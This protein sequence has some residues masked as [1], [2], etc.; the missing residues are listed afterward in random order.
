M[1]CVM[2][3]LIVYC[4]VGVV[5][6][7][8]HHSICWF[9]TV[10]LRSRVERVADTRD[11]LCVLCSAGTYENWRP[12]QANFTAADKGAALPDWPGEWWLNTR[13]TNVR[14][15]M[16]RVSDGCIK[17]QDTPGD[18]RGDMPCAVTRAA[19]RVFLVSTSDA[20]GVVYA[21][22]SDVMT[23]NYTPA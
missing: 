18:G 9:S 3:T 7:M 15:I 14:N 22:G 17:A 20:M 11:V 2:N 19:S 21:R 12:D 1:C 6:H 16:A 5:G 23:C 13:S 8:R 4:S 10:H